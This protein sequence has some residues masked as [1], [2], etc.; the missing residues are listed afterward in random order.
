MYRSTRVAAGLAALLAPPC[1][2]RTAVPACSISAYLA[3][4]DPTGTNIRSAPSSA[5]KIVSRVAAGTD[6]VVEIV[7][8]RGGWF[9]VSAVREVGDRDATLFEGNGWIHRSVLG[10]DVANED[11]R[12]YAFPRKGARVSAKL[13]ADGSRV[14]LIG[15]SGRWAQVRFGNRSGWL[16][17]GGQCASPLTTCS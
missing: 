11:P 8:Q 16:S 4:S 14:T 17:P 5:S 10:I 13:F 6:A 3:D 9:R 15:C 2:A 7:G 1:A 12:L